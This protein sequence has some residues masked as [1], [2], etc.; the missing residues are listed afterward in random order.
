[1]NDPR[2]IVAGD[3]QNAPAIVETLSLAFQDD[4][5]VS[6]ILPDANQRRV[7][8]PRMFGILTPADLAS[9]MA[10]RSPGDEVASLWRA[11]G[12]A[13]TPTLQM[14]ALG[15]PLMR[16]FGSA[17]A[18][19]LGVSGAIDGHHPKGIDYW[20]LHYVG[21]RPQSQGKGWGGAVVRAGLER[22]RSEGKP[23]F[24]E[25]ATPANVGL[26]QNLGFRVLSEWDVP[27]GGPHFWS[28]LAD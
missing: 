17:L 25:T 6:W 24:L 11:P 16:T 12:K 21:V 23:V 22:A 18:R 2:L 4:P 19:A 10:L 7:R 8:L 5:A 15:W 26:Y 27:R 13:H 14:L 1:M 20:Y 28:M 9:G 3:A